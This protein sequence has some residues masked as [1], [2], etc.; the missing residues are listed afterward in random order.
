MVRLSLR[1]AQPIKHR[2]KVM[3]QTARNI[4]HKEPA[5]T[6]ALVTPEGVDLR[7]QLADM[8][9][10]FGAFFIDLAIITAVIVGV[11]FIYSITFGLS[12]Q[13]DSEIGTVLLTMLWFF[14]RS[15][16]FIAFE[17]SRHA[18]TPGKRLLKIRVTSRDGGRLTAPAVFSRNAMRELEFFLPLQFL[19]F[20]GLTQESGWLYLAGTIWFCV[21]LFF[22]LFNRDNLRAGDI[23]GGTWVIRAPRPILAKD[24]SDKVL[25]DN[26]EFDFTPQQLKAY[27]I[28]ELHVL[29]DVIR[30]NDL[31]TIVAVADRIRAKLAWEKGPNE[32]S[33]DFLS[34]YYSGLRKMLET[35]MV[36]GK[37]RKDKFDV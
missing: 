23:V 36:F 14:L 13:G 28:H 3:S 11:M 35:Q 7:I 21:F 16:Y 33:R 27:G 10:R 29:E 22:P 31:A 12:S 34:A 8:G 24:L 19:L 1:T 9:A 2:I 18:A 20:G 4:H 5:L 25:P 37:R 17:I 26:V 32:K 15:F 30:N 6:R